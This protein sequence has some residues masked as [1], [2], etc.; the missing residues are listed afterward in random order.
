MENNPVFILMVGISSSGKST[1]AEKYAKEND[2]I[3]HSSD[4]LRKELLGDYSDQTKNDLI[5]STLRKR[6]K[7]DLNDG[8]NVICDA[9]NITIKERRSMLQ[10]VNSIDCIKK[11]FVISRKIDECISSNNKRDEKVPDYVVY[12][13]AKKFEIPFYEEGFD[14]IK[15]FSLS[16]TQMKDSMLNK[17]IFREYDLLMNGFNQNNPHHKYT[18]DEHCR[19]TAIELSKNGINNINIIR[20][21]MYHDIGKV[22]TKTNDENNI[23]HY[24]GHHNFGAYMILSDTSDFV[25]KNVFF[26]EYD[27]LEM[28]FYVN[29]HMLPFFWKEEKT[30]NKYKRLFGEEKYNNLILFNKCDKIASGTER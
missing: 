26:K 12:K 13:Q 7:K 24:Y 3:I 27:F 25:E 22:Y 10:N 18:L 19:R 21:A 28:L 16:K 29:Y 9:T 5:F 30:H 6:I 11:A 1:F 4:E 15:I 20:S 14:E 23:S 8:K 17:Y 2:F